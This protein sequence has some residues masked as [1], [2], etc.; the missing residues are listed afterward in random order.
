VTAGNSSQV[1]DGAC[2]LLLASEAAIKTHQLP[3]LGEIIDCDWQ[4]LDPKYMGLGPA[5][6]VASLLTKHELNL[7][8][9][10]TLEINEAFAVQVLACLEAWNDRD[11][12]QAELALK[13]ALGA[14]DRTKLNPE[15]GAIAT[16]H[17]I[18]AS[19]ARI[20]LHVLNMLKKKNLKRGIATLCI[21]GGQGG[22]ML[23]ETGE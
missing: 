13:H 2:L 1:T 17:P 12:C 20:V 11:Y 19:G 23:L 3:V 21:G 15:G 10:D 22:A 7:N 14:F 4:A 9:I 8:D 6:A 5:H 18:G 16:G